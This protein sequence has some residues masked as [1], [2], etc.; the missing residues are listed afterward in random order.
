M[1]ERGGDI[2][3]IF[4]RQSVARERLLKPQQKS[5][6]FEAKGQGIETSTMPVAKNFPK[7]QDSIDSM[8]RPYPVRNHCQSQYSRVLIVQDFA[9]RT[10]RCT[11]FDC[12]LPLLLF[13]VGECGFVSTSSLT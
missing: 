12:A 1:D 11:S 4:C 13:F 7:V 2:K 10:E 8:E 3:I 5:P 9:D 6:R